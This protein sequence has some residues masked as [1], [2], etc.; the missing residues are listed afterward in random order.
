MKNLQKIILKNNE[1]IIK[2]IYWNKFFKK[3][4]KDISIA[5]YIENNDIFLREK[6]TSVLENFK[7]NNY[8]YFDEF[9]IEKDFSFWLLTNFEEKNLY[10]KNKF[11]ELTKVIAVIE[12][13]KTLTF[14]DIHVDIEDKI[15][16]ETIKNILNNQK[17]KKKT[18]YNKFKI[19]FLFELFSSFKAIFFLFSKL[20]SSRKKISFNKEYNLFISFFSYI[21]KEEF[22]KGN[23]I[24]LFWGSLKKIVNMNILNL[25]IKND[26]DNNFRQLNYKL[27]DLSN[28]NEIHNFLD[29]FLDL[30]T[31]WKIFIVS[32]K[33]KIRFHKNVN[34]FKFLYDNKDISPIMLFDLGR[35][36]LFF[37][38]VIKLYYFYLFDNF[39]KKNNFNHNC[40]YI[41]E[42][43]P[44]EKSLIYHWKK[45]NKG[46]IF[47][48]VSS[49]VRFWDIRYKKTKF[50]PDVLLANGEDSFDKLL[51]FGYKDS[52]VKKVESL[53]YDRNLYFEKS[54]SK[55][56]KEILLLLDYSKKSNE[57]LTNVLN[58]SELIKNY[59][60]FI[61][62]HPLNNFKSD[63][64]NFK[65][66]KSDESNLKKK[67]DLVICTNR[68]TA[69]VD[70]YLEGQKIAILL[71]SDFFNFSPL[72]GNIHCDFFYDNI[73]L[74]Q[75]LKNT[76]N[77][78][79]KNNINSNFFLINTEFNEWK[80]IFK[81]EK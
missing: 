49:S 25:Y 55:E 53:R 46:N 17:I 13:A 31:I 32:L 19:N 26:I 27:H 66:Y 76:S 42:N 73:E 41:H 54:E 59:K 56:K 69:S 48:V 74:D 24:S 38:I 30:K 60:I 34:K 8:Q 2:T 10:K 65:F 52:D 62:E 29:T 21:K 47:G 23:Y 68:T 51:N 61:K 20:F 15:Y 79:R 67:F 80:K 75:I 40:F 14:N 63:K 6:L 36:Y 16:K 77:K 33:I 9:K 57:L 50:N 4:N 70:Y 22:K 7:K 43:Q 12:I 37:N 3:N 44:W 81:Y 39:F 28:K 18:N 64:L 78:G 11:Y 5:N 45:N 71:E 1:D 58:K 35:N 72:K